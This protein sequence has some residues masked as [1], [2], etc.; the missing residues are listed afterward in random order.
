[1]EAM[2][3]MAVNKDIKR[4]S[5]IW[6]FNLLAVTII[7]TSITALALLAGCSAKSTVDGNVSPGTAK[8]QTGASAGIDGGGVENG[9]G[10]EEAEGAGAEIY[11]AAVTI[12][13]ENLNNSLSETG[14]SDGGTGTG[15]ENASWDGQPGGEGSS[16]GVEGFRTAPPVGGEKPPEKEAGS[17]ALVVYGTEAFRK[18][19][20]NPGGSSIKLGSDIVFTTSTACDLE[21]GALIAGGN[22]IID[23]NGFTMQYSYVDNYRN[24]CG[25]VVYLQGGT[26]TINGDGYC[27][28][29]RFAFEHSGQFTSTTIN[30][31]NYR[32]I[33]G[34]GMR[35]RN[36]V[37]IINAGVFSGPFGGAFLEEGCLVDMTGN[38]G[39][40]DHRGGAYIKGGIL[41]GKCVLTAPLKLVNLTVPSG[42][43]ID[44]RE[45]AVLNITGALSGREAIG[46]QSGMLISGGEGVVYGRTELKES[47]SV[48]RLTVQAGAT[49]TVRSGVRLTVTGNAVNNGT[50]DVMVSGVLDVKGSITNNG[51]I[52]G[53]KPP[54]APQPGI[55]SGLSM[56]GTSPD[57]QPGITTPVKEPAATPYS[58]APG[59][60]TPGS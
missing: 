44:I 56:P 15:E 12:S 3:M 31:G 35:L 52:T 5:I 27:I 14:E 4:N 19:L 43:S 54:D 55:S 49:L 22:H 48:N 59:S 29:G 46:I 36:G 40:Y 18:A 41:Y 13:D 39:R 34:C 26:L 37:T 1:M 11:T 38:I 50:I 45:G 21:C 53:L 25:T 42:S 30:G 51:S 33:E 16:S 8:T 24:T 6:I 32:G 28:G 17:S 2:K 20:E 9:D 58:P 10:D 23:L 7:I 47:V 57:L 60:P